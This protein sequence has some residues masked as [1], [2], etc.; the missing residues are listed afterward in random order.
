MELWELTAREG[1]RDTIA[2]YNNAGDHGHLDEL[3]A[4]FTADGVMH[5]KGRDPLVGRD[6]IVAALTVTLDERLGSRAVEG[7]H[8]HHHVASTCF[9]AVA[10]DLVE[11][12]SYFAVHT[13][14]GLDHWGR[15]RDE[16]VPS[17]EPWLFRRRR[18]ATDGYAP[19]SLFAPR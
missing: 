18:I 2:R 4:C 11:V 10:P 9:L 12:A 16:L 15:Y 1:V 7:F 13:P 8:V 3:A 19:G 14:V 17:G 6:A 5:I